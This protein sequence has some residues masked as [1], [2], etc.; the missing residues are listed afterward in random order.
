MCYGNLTSET[1]LFLLSHAA[2]AAAAPECC[3]VT[4]LG[5]PPRLPNEVAVAAGVVHGDGV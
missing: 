2:A 1:L 3:W 5:R 4:D